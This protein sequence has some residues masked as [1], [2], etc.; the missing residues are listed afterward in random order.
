[1]KSSVLCSI[2]AL[3]AT[4]CIPSAYSHRHKDDFPAVVAPSDRT[5]PAKTTEHGRTYPESVLLNL[6]AETASQIKSL[7]ATVVA[8]HSI[9]FEGTEGCQEVYQDWYRVG[10]AF[11]YI[12]GKEQVGAWPNTVNRV[13]KAKFCGWFDGNSAGA[14][15]RDLKSNNSTIDETHGRPAR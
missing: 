15:A 6:P 3:F 10:Y 13:E 5:S 2:A 9:H 14:L 4:G 11:A 7:S 1:M 8:P 12:I